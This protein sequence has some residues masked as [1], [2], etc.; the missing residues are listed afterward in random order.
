MRTAAELDARRRGFSPWPGAWTTAAGSVLKIHDARPV[1]GSGAP[2][3]L[4]HGTTF[5]TGG[6]TA[7]E[8][9]EVQ[10]EGKKRMPAS[11]WLQGARLGPNARLGT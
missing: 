5:A 3:M 2:G 1:Q 9:R 8:L 4:L 11:A 6:N 10:P 7:W